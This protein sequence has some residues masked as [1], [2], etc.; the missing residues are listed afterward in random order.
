MAILTNDEMIFM[1]RLANKQGENWD[2]HKKS[3]LK[4]VAQEVEDKMVAEFASMKVDIKVHTDAAGE[5]ELTNAEVKL[6]FDAYG[7][8]KWRQRTGN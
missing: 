6:F 7:R 1:Q 2:G 5:L 3:T 4:L 8:M